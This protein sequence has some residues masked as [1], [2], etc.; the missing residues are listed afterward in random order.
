MSEILKNVLIAELIWFA[1]AATQTFVRAANTLAPP[2]LDSLLLLLFLFYTFVPSCVLFNW[3]IKRRLIDWP[4]DCVEM[5]RLSCVQSPSVSNVCSHDSVNV[6]S[7]EVRH[8]TD[9]TLRLDS[10]PGTIIQ[11]RRLLV[12]SYRFSRCVHAITVRSQKYTVNRKSTPKCFFWYTVYKTC[13]KI[14]Y[15]LSWATLSYRSVNVSRLTWIASLPCKWNIFINCN[16][17]NQ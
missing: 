3:L 2:L 9:E 7:L 4:T 6:Q 14:W 17:K 5:S 8:I 1:G 11:L 12:R 13:D 10:L 15:I 16:W